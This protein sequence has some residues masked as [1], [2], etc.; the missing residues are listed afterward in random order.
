MFTIL[1]YLENYKNVMVKDVHWNNIDNL[2]CAILVY[3]PLKTFSASKSLEDFYLASQEVKP[4]EDKMGEMVKTA[5]ASLEI[6]RNSERYKN[7]KVSNF[8]NLT[9]DNTQFGACTFR[10]SKKTIVSFKGTDSS[11]IGW[12]ENF[13]VTY[14]YPTFTHN[15]AIEYL[16]TNTN[17]LS[18]TEVY[19]VGH[20]KGGNLAIVSAME[21][22]QNI[23]K[24][25][26]FIYNFDGPGLRKEQFE[27]TAY[28]KVSKKLLNIL[29]TG[30][31]VGVLLYN[32][33]YN[34]VET[35]ALAFSQHY[36]VNWSIFGEFFESGVI[37]NVSAQLHENTTT[38]FENLDPQQ[39]QDA[40]ETV[41]LN[42]EKSFSSKLNFSFDDV[43]KFYKNIKNLDPAISQ[44]IE[45]TLGTVLKSV[46]GR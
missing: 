22:P 31:V 8:I 39:V 24:K 41:F 23:F 7:L 10:I 1:D 28:K 4:T 15:L 32:D 29:P 45:Q 9:T 35:N 43:I 33:N 26:K 14:S 19:V 44:S 37:S 2:L 5:Y 46:A 40:F 36:P 16:K 21:A 30:S 11:I 38:G 42:L 25:I 13:R 20:S 34:I 12:I 3:I 17:K 18:D 27:G 6:I